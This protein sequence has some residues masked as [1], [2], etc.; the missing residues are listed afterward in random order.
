MGRHDMPL[1]PAD[2]D[3]NIHPE[4]LV[5]LTLEVTAHIRDAGHIVLRP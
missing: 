5:T 2:G 4:R 3:L 1:L